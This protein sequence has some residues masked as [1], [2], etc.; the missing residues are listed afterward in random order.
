LHYTH[1]IQAYYDTLKCRFITQQNQHQSH[2]DVLRYQLVRIKAVLRSQGFLQLIFEAVEN[3]RKNTFAG[4]SLE[5]YLNEFWI[6]FRL[7]NLPSNSPQF[8]STF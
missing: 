3:N 8:S 6:I 4:S 5:K 7:L 2:L 1:V